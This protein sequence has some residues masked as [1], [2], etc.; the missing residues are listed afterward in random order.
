VPY[1]VAAPG[2][3]T[4]IGQTSTLSSPMT[5]SL[6]PAIDPLGSA[7]VDTACLLVI[8]VLPILPF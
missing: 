1:R 8:T 3:L 5:S 4:T 2:D 6:A 7:D